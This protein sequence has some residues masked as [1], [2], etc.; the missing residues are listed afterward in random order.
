M[1]VHGISSTKGFYFYFFAIFSDYIVDY[2]LCQVVTPRI[3]SLVCFRL[4]P[5]CKDEAF[6][7][8]L[9]HDLLNAVNSTGKAFISHTVSSLVTSH[10]DLITIV[11][12]LALPQDVKIS[13]IFGQNTGLIRKIRITFCGRSSIDRRETC[14]CGMD[15]SARES[16]CLVRN[17]PIR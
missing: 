16:L 14:K 17:H 6:A 11:P 9:N 3:F 13:I 12:N 15:H 10:F 4:L 7:N 5:A 2:L 8:K 1:S